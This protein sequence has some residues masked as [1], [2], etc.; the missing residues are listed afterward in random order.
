[1]IFYLKDINGNEVQ[2]RADEVAE[3]MITGFEEK[4]EAENDIK[5]FIEFFLNNCENDINSEVIKE[6]VDTML[7]DNIFSICGYEGN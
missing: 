6:F 4:Y 2:I 3:A 1:M 5:K 7:N